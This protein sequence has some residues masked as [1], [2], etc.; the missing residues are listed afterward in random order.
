M[1]V[2]R[3]AG[4]SLRRRPVVR[5]PSMETHGRLVL[6]L[7]LLFIFAVVEVRLVCV[8]V[9]SDGEAI[10]GKVKK[11]TCI[12]CMKRE[13]ILATTKVEWFYKG[14]DKNKTRTLIYLYDGEPQE[15]KDVDEQWKGR[16]TW[17]GSKDM[18]DVS[19]S[20]LNVT[21]NDTGTY[22]CEVTRFFEFDSFKLSA[23]KNIRINLKVNMRA[24]ADITALYSEIMMYVL[25]VFLTFW[26]LVEMVYCYRKISKSDEQA[27]D[28]AY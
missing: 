15:P 14:Q 5:T 26:L 6:H 24:S 13:E 2:S 19:I 16:V 23:N 4:V 25:L 11:L 8:D 12:Y 1:F 9:P 18:Q 7:L 10:V 21:L 28:T 27:Q 20:I 22:E 3:K 17:T